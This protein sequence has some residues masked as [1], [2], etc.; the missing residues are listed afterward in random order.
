MI[1]MMTIWL[2]IVTRENDYLLL[3]FTYVPAIYQMIRAYYLKQTPTI[4][5]HRNDNIITSILQEMEAQWL[6]FNLNIQ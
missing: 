4:P 6:S 1:S 2:R 5:W 3:R